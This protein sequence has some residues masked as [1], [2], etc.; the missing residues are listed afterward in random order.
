MRRKVT[1][2]RRHKIVS[3]EGDFI[4]SEVLIR[5]SI[6]IRRRDIHLGRWGRFEQV[7]QSGQVELANV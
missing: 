5:A 1:L 2:I 7:K 6:R 3:Y 4:S